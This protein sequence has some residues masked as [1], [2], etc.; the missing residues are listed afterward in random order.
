[1][2][3]Q[4]ELSGIH[5]TYESGTINE[6]Y[7]LKGVDLSL[8][9]GD[10]VTIIGSNGAGKSTL[11]NTITGAVIPDEGSILING[12]DI[13][14]W[15]SAKRA[16]LIGYVFQDPRMG[17]AAHLTIEENLALAYRRGLSRGLSRGVKNTDREF[18][19][20]KLEQLG[21]GLEHRL[22]TE[23]G[24]LS[25]GQRQ[26]VTL[27]M[28]T[29]RRPELLLLDEHTAALDPQTSEMVLKVTQRTVIKEKLTAL[30]VTHNM[31]DALRFGNRLIMLHQGRV[32]L[33]LSKE[34]KRN[35]TVF[36]LLELF[37]QQ[38]GESN[39]SDALLLT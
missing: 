6:N 16:A 36:D 15:S 19:R 7:V 18:F 26:A 3:K 34:E 38:S 30:M 9:A 39:A 27:L 2:M 12:V 28:A 10:F 8:N 35:M 17:T 32:L 25:G 23:I 11:M 24:F 22:G 13:S 5:K 14:K 1:M 4:L 33:D 29:L 21:L 20:G 31:E 37:K